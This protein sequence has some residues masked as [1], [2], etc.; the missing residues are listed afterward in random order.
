MFGY[1]EPLDPRAVPPRKAPPSVGWMSETARSVA[2]IG[3]WTA[4]IGQGGYVTIYQVL[5]P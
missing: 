3:G 2:R 5:I 4:G 1:N